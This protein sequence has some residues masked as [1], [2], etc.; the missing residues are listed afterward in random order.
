MQKKES[1]L[2]YAQFYDLHLKKSNLILRLND[3]K[4]Q[5]R[6]GFDFNKNAQTNQK[7]W[8]TLTNVINE[9]LIQITQTKNIEIPFYNDFKPFAE[10]SLQFSDLLKQITSHVYLFHRQ[11]NIWDNAFQLY[12][13]LLFLS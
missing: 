2:D 7:K 8:E 12:S 13:S 10:S 9:N 6:Q 5:F 1:T 3:Y 11:Q 4:Y